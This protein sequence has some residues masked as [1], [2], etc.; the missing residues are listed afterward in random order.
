M[1]AIEVRIFIC[2]YMI[3]DKTF[4]NCT[5]MIDS[6]FQ[7]FVVGLLVKFYRLVLH[8]LWQGGGRNVRDYL[9]FV[10]IAAPLVKR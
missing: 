3:V 4:F 1:L 6:P 7:T 2:M 5:L 8:A 9:T 10:F